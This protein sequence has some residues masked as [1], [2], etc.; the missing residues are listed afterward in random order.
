M[1]INHHSSMRGGGGMHAHATS[2]FGAKPG[3]ERTY[4]SSLSR[5]GF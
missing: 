5:F 1:I 3:D 2:S 4:L